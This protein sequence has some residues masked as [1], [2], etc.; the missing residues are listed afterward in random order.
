M[1]KVGRS[2]RSNTTIISKAFI[3]EDV[4]QQSSLFLNLL[5]VSPKFVQ[6]FEVSFVNVK[7]NWF[8]VLSAGHIVRLTPTN[9][10]PLAVVYST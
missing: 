5:F 4:E 8:G 9:E 6:K 2:Y 1:F 10:T 7:E 3:T